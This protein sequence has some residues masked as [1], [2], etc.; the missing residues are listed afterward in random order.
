ME[1]FLE[2]FCKE[3]AKRHAHEFIGG[4]LEERLGTIENPKVTRVDLFYAIKKGTRVLSVASKTDKK[5]GKVWAR[6]LE[7]Y[8]DFFTPELVL[9]GLAYVRPDLATLIAEMKEG[10]K[11]LEGEVKRLRKFFWG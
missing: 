6:R 3:L 2:V 10:K 9:K 7:E 1:R 8:K 11:W 5:F 4:Y